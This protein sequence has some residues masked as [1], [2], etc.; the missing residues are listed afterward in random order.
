[1][2]LWN[3]RSAEDIY[4]V[5]VIESMEKDEK[6][7][8]R[9]LNMD[10]R[11]LILSINPPG[12]YSG[13]E[14]FEDEN[15]RLRAGIMRKVLDPQAIQFMKIPEPTEAPM[16]MID[17]LEGKEDARTGITPLVEGEMPVTGNSKSKTNSEYLV[18]REASLR[19]L[20]IPKRH[21]SYAL[22]W[23]FMNRIALIQQVYSDFDVEHLED[24]EAIFEYL[25][26][27]NADPDFFFIE[28]EGQAGKEKFH[29]KRYREVPLAVEQDEH[30][31]FLES[32][33]ERFFHIK[34]Q[35]LAWRGT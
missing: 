22:K 34:P 30:G 18:S 26:E 32:E 23:E 4:G 21:L 24:K 20:Q 17:W 33:D 14:D 28:N 10:L 12:F 19:K 9:I 13:T 3:L 29:A 5:G 8:D 6:L 1:M 25:D 27:V 31:E 15:I 35:W 16:A 7:I 2:A 11:Q